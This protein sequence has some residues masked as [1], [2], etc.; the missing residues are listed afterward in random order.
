MTNPKSPNNKNINMTIE[1]EK[2]QDANMLKK[3]RLTVIV[4]MM[5]KKL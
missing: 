5:L 4:A 3:V 2:N 1:D